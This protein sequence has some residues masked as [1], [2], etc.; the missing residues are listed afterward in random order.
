MNSHIVILGAGSIGCY[1]G[2]RLLASSAKV[3][4]LGRD[5]LIEATSSKGMTISD[6]QG[7]HHEYTPDLININNHESMLNQADIIIVC[8]KSKDTQI[9]AMQIKQHA[10]P[11]ALVVTFQNGT[12][13]ADTIASICDQPVLAGSVPFGVIWKD[14]TTFHQTTQGKLILEA[15]DGLE[16]E[17]VSYFSQAQFSVSVTS[18]IKSLL[19]S[20]LLLNMNNGIN[21]LA[22]MPLIEGLK[23]KYY[24]KAIALC[25]KEAIGLM[26]TANIDIMK[27]GTTPTSLVPYVLTLPTPV[28][29]LI[30]KKMLAMDKHARSSML[31]DLEKLREPEVDYINGEVVRLANSLGLSAPINERVCQLVMDA[32]K[33]NKGSPKLPPVKIM[34]LINT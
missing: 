27:I 20:K 8:V 16:E 28:F 30:A 4:F 29:N 32:H 5:K 14:H 2:G 31:D 21:A 22:G 26:K 25:M 24:R 15:R 11:N 23:D 19:W 10:K 7:Y 13:N 6:F 33:Q 1:I 12:L 34:Q 18:N 3:S 17:L 9:A